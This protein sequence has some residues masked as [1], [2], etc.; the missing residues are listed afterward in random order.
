MPF[1]N[2]DNY[3]EYE[4]QHFKQRAWL[5]YFK[6]TERHVSLIVEKQQHFIYL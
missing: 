6:A 3:D 1:N 2:D 5:Y 4:Q